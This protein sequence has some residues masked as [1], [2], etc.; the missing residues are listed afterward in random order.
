MQLASLSMQLVGKLHRQLDEREYW[1]HSRENK[2][3]WLTVLLMVVKA[4]LRRLMG[5]DDDDDEKRTEALR[6]KTLH[7]DD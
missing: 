4:E 7:L 5:W 6:M 1:R 2:V 3:Q